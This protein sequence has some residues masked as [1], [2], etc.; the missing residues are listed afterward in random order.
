MY[1]TAEVWSQLG[2]FVIRTL[3]LSLFL[4]NLR[5]LLLAV[6]PKNR[7][8]KPNLVW[9]N[10]IP[11]FDFVWIFVTLLKVRDSVRSQHRDWAWSVK[12]TA[13]PVGMISAVG[14]VISQLSA[15]L[16]FASFVAWQTVLWMTYVPALICWI[17][18]WVRTNRLKNELTRA[19]LGVVMGGQVVPTSAVASSSASAQ[20]PTPACVSCGLRGQPGDEFC[21]SCGASLATPTA[22]IQASGAASTGA[23]CAFCGAPYRSGARFCS[24]CGRPAS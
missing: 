12:D 17:V 24:S 14:Y 15:F 10:L 3:I 22:D 4:L 5:R 7:A 2:G 13:F 20:G 23:I 1:D 19:S 16:A 18:Y 6:E 21:R 8:M 11:V 9:L